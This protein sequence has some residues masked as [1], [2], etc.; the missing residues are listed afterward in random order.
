VTEGGISEV[1]L[2]GGSTRIPKVQEIIENR[3][4]N[5]VLFAQ[6]PDECVAQGAA[7][8]AY[9]KE[10]KGVAGIPEVEVL[11][12]LSEMLRLTDIANTIN[13]VVIGD[14]SQLNEVSS[15]FDSL[16]V[17]DLG[18]GSFRI[19]STANFKRAPI[20]KF[21]QHDDLDEERK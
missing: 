1:V 21:S 7:F 14:A 19:K 11:S 17:K 5:K 6:N 12:D 8:F 20:L 16:K 15:S 3:F 13:V 2:V 9:M 18:D 10:N 4:G